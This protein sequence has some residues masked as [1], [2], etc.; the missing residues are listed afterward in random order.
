MKRTRIARTDVHHPH[1]YRL[2]T[3]MWAWACD[4][5]GA[6]AR[7]HLCPSPW[8]STLVGALYHASSVAA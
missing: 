3:G 8:H 6:S 5:G 2:P 1:V 7:A 4:C